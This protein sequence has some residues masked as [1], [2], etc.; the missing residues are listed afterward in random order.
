MIAFEDI[1]DVEAWLAPL[2]Y[3]AFWDAIAPWAVFDR[4]DRAHFDGVIAR[5]VTS[6]ETVLTCLK[7]AV[8]LELTARFGLK[9]RVYEPVE[10]QYLR[11][12]H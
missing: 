6:E 2:D 3:D 11:R 5:G 8:R 7:A 9:D 10:R 4:E 1:D 12:T